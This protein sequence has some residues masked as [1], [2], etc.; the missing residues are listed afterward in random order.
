MLKTAAMPLQRYLLRLPL[1]VIYR[2]QVKSRTRDFSTLDSIDLTVLDFFDTA[3]EEIEDVY[4]AKPLVV[5]NVGRVMRRAQTPNNTVDVHG[6]SP[7]EFA[8]AGVD[9]FF[10]SALRSGL[11]QGHLPKHR[12]QR[13]PG[14]DA[15]QPVGLHGRAGHRARSLGILDARA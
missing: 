8:L 13:S 5:R 4:G 2:H 11:V 12:R 9:S 7:H 3:I 1:V 14:L 10:S 6:T 15:C